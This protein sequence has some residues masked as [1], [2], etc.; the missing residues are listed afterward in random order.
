MASATQNRR[1]FGQAYEQPTPCLPNLHD[2]VEERQQDDPAGGAYVE[3]RCLYC[4]ELFAVHEIHPSLF[5]DEA[6]HEAI[7]ARERDRARM[8]S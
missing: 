8:A 7:R 4:R 6:R 3:M 2:L 5:V 1:R